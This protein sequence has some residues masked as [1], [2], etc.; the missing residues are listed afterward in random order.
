VNLIVIGIVCVLLF[1]RRLPEIARSLG[2]SFV[3]FKRGLKDVS[4]EV[5]DVSD[6]TKNTAKDISSEKNEG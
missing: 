2:R 4:N 3:E 6:T 1:G 5:T